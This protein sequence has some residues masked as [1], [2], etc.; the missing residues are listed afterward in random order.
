MMNCEQFSFSEKLSLQRISKA[1]TYLGSKVVT[2]ILAF[3][4]FLLGANKTTI[5]TTL[6]MPLG[7]VK[8]LILAINKIGL[9]GIEDQRKKTPTF[10]PPDSI[11]KVTP[12][13]LK[14]GAEVKI[15]FEP[16]NLT[17]HIPDS[18]PVQKKVILLSLLNSGCFNKMEVANA[19]NLSTDRTG[20][21][22]KKL[23][24]EDVKGIIDNRQGQEQDYVFKP[25]I[26]GELIQQFV[27]EVVNNQPTSAQHLSNKL[28]NR[29]NLTLSSRS[30]LDHLTKL[31]LSHIKTS[32]PSNIANLKKKYSDS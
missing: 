32:L 3:A 26:K 16:E 27:L 15:I 17:L 23:Q 19:L 31:G 12:T 14:E 8:S 9:A 4:L 18:N 22:A 13:L 2:K 21:L 25:E 24:L 1:K 7:S 20:K 30:I 11:S 28:K 29:C 10:K 6:K 5:A